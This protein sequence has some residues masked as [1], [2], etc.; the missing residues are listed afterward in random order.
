M[1]ADLAFDISAI[2][3][4]S[5]NV[6]EIGC[7]QG[8]AILDAQFL[9]PSAHM[10]CVNKNLYGI[11][12]ANERRHLLSAAAR[13]GVSLQCDE[14]N[15]PILPS[16]L[17]IESIVQPPSL[18]SLLGA[19]R[20]DFVYSIHA[21][22]N[23]FLANETHIWFP[24]VVRLLAGHR[25][26]LGLLHIGDLPVVF[27]SHKVGRTTCL[28]RFSVADVHITMCAVANAVDSL[29]QYLVAYICDVLN[30][31][32]VRNMDLLSSDELKELDEAVF[33][34]SN[35]AFQHIA[36]NG[37]GFEQAAWKNMNSRLEMW[38]HVSKTSSSDPLQFWRMIRSSIIQNR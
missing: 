1:Y 18:V 14:S 31:P 26:A 25:H 9:A 21:L 27:T 17:L 36:K 6:L 32:Y 30:C 33:G 7:G 4:D 10:V 2:I 24:D 34:G 29:G 11:V 12:Q 23:K 16:V 22:N 20:F 37:R 35:A 28:K 13:F 38:E 3:R 8:H 19:R 5:S 15:E